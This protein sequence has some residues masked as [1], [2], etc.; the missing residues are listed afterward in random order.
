MQPSRMWVRCRRR[1]TSSCWLGGL[2][3]KPELLLNDVTNGNSFAIFHVLVIKVQRIVLVYTIKFGFNDHG[4]I[5][6]ISSFWPYCPLHYKN[7]NGYNNVTV[8]MNIYW[9]FHR[10]RYIRCNITLLTFFNCVTR[11]WWSLIRLTF[12]V[13]FLTFFCSFYIQPFYDIPLLKKLSLK[14]IFCNIFS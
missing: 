14:Y 5:E 2:E 10:V 8:T 13:A 6:F 12:K 7:I 4:Y 3:K 1:L 11:K 9:W